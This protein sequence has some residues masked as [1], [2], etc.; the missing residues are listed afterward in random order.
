MEGA[1]GKL[2][3]M[4]RSSRRNGERVACNAAECH[5]SHGTLSKKQL[6]R[7]LQPMSVLPFSNS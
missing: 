6:L 4:E 7:F 2:L 1:R 3:Q 5:D